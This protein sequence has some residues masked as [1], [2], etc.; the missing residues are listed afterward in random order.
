MYPPTY[1][2]SQ[3][4]LPKIEVSDFNDSLS[5]VPSPVA[6]VVPRGLHLGDSVDNLDTNISR[7]SLPSPSKTHDF[8]EEEAELAAIVDR[9]GNRFPGDLSSGKIYF[10]G[11]F[12]FFSQNKIELNDNCSKTV[13]R[14]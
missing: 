6:E 1:D 10:H 12:A 8:G 13:L 3:R 2:Q 9:M 4:Y 14:K 11:L 5:P 7:F